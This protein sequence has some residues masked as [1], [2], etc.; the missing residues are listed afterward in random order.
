[1]A[2]LHVGFGLSSSAPSCSIGVRYSFQA[3]LI[4]PRTTP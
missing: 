1:M 3:R 2:D 4:H